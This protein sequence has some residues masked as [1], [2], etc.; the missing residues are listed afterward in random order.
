MQQIMAQHKIKTEFEIWTTFVLHHSKAS[1]DFKF[2]E[3]IGSIS[4]TLK[5]RFYSTILDV[6]GGNTFEHL[7]KFAV[8]AYQVTEEEFRAATKSQSEGEDEERKKMPF[9]SFPWLL[10]DTL[11][12][13]VS[14]AHFQSRPPPQIT[15]DPVE[16]R[17]TQGH[18]VQEDTLQSKT[19]ASEPETTTI[20]PEPDNEVAT[21]FE[22]VEAP[23]APVP[24]TKGGIEKTVIVPASTRP[25]DPFLLLNP[26]KGIEMTKGTKTTNKTK[27]KTQADLKPELKQ[28][29][30]KVGSHVPQ[31][32]KE[33]H[34]NG[35]RNGESSDEG[36]M[37]HVSQASSSDFCPLNSMMLNDGMMKD[38][39]D[40][41]AEEMAA[42]GL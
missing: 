39:A 7:S 19:D 2:H 8:A 30:V 33:E 20:K 40:M 15:S 41:T 28:K 38:P 25:S 11:G 14:L 26:F 34:S 29:E 32:V 10:A 27:T 23:A 31:Q 5:D 3:E 24:K 21:D 4:K 42:L 1:G 36:S 17:T 22:M 13:I 16:T 18:E 6:C 35:S 12:K 9:I 37:V